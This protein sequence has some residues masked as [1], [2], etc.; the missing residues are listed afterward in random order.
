MLTFSIETSTDEN[1]LSIDHLVQNLEYGVI[2]SFGYDD[3]SY[4]PSPVQQAK[5]LSSYTNA[6]Q[7]NT[8][9]VELKLIDLIPENS[10]NGFRYLFR[11]VF[12]WKGDTGT[13]T[14]MHFIF[15]IIQRLQSQDYLNADTAT[16]I[17]YDIGP[18]PEVDQKYTAELAP[19]PSLRDLT[20]AIQQASEMIPVAQSKIQAT[21]DV[22]EG[23]GKDIADIQ[24]QI[25]NIA[26]T[27]QHS[28][29]PQLDA[30]A[31]KY[32]DL[33]KQVN[34][35]QTT[36]DGI[37]DT[38]VQAYRTQIVQ[39]QAQARAIAEQAKSLDLSTATS[40]Q[41]VSL[42]GR[43]NDLQ[44]ELQGMINDLRILEGQTQAMSGKLN[45]IIGN[46]TGIGG[47][48][49]DAIKPYLIPAAIGFVVMM[50]LLR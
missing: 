6:V 31:Q 34:D 49:F 22:V 37:K 7:F 23:L 3:P 28:D 11:L 35:V 19:T 42:Q 32:M 30:I 14:P 25:A 26:H 29:Q 21:K 41:I 38:D 36:L 47:L 16:M 12:V 48:S 8:P 50:L 39:L 17:E 13:A 1:R 43:A 20:D 15:P 46:S 45:S 5:A 4:Q 27:M 9:Y 24:E 33:V 2:Y 40:N 18:I 10:K 44:T